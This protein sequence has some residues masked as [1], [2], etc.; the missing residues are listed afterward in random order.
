MFTGVVKGLTP[1][2]DA[3]S[4]TLRAR[5]YVSENDTSF[6]PNTY[7]NVSFAID[8]GEQLVVP[9]SALLDTGKH[10]LV[11]TVHDKT[12]FRPQEVQTGASWN[13]WQVINTGVKEGDTVASAAL[14][15]LDSEAQLRMGK[16]GEHN[17]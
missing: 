4:R 13:E 14:F 11:Y 17:H 15:L 1:V 3:S 8:L 2:V 10:K 6:K 9:K 16:A 7:V 5:I 12:H